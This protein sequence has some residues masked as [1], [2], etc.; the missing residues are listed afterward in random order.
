MYVFPL[1]YCELDC[2]YHRNRSTRLGLAI[3]PLCQ[4]PP[5]TNTGVPFDKMKCFE[6]TC[7]WKCSK[8]FCALVVTVKT[9]VLTAT[10]EKG[11]QLFCIREFAPTAG[12]KSRG[13][14]WLLLMPQPLKH[15]QSVSDSAITWSRLMTIL[16]YVGWDVY[17][18]PTRSHTGEKKLFDVTDDDEEN[19]PVMWC[20]LTH[21]PWRMRATPTPSRWPIN[22]DLA[23]GWRWGEGGE[24]GGGRRSSSENDTVNLGDAIVRTWKRL[25]I[26]PRTRG[27]C[28]RRPRTPDNYYLRAACLPIES[29][30]AVHCNPGR[31]VYTGHCSGRGGMA[32]RIGRTNTTVTQLAWLLTVFFA[33]FN[34]WGP[35]SSDRQHL[36]YVCLE[37]KGE[38][39][40]IGTVLCCVVYWSCAQ[41]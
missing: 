5:S 41:S 34:S 39:K 16:L 23:Y 30:T 28:S 8:V 27:A 36:S 26:W 29:G 31:G 32:P 7:P 14:P 11:R 6:G 9:C 3:V 13:R 35:L 4:A 24:K 12:K 10:T 17:N 18:A 1:D 25:V 38:I 22:E 37:V 21:A 15:P 33:V 2:Q 19:M 40:L 20:E